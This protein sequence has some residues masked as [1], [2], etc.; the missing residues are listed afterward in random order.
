MT[1]TIPRNDLARLLGA[2]VK[3]VESRHTIPIL[4]TVRLVA[5]DD[6]LTVTAT[7][8]DIEVASSAPCSGALSVCVDAKLLAGIVAKA[9][10]ADV[11]LSLADTTLTVKSGRSGFRCCTN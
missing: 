5:A 11:S 2:T 10:G 3:V 7:D 8:L 4:S 1:L 6:R 9:A